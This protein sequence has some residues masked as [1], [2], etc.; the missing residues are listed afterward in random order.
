MIPTEGNLV[1]LQ[2]SLSRCRYFTI[3]GQKNKYQLLNYASGETLGDVVPILPFRLR[4]NCF[5]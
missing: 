3:Q 1:L 5:A 2:V 4:N